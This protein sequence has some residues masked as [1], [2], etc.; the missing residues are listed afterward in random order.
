VTSAAVHYEASTICKM[1]IVWFNRGF[2]QATMLEIHDNKKLA[3]H[4]AA[5]RKK[6]RPA[7]P[8][9]SRNPVAGTDGRSFW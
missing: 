9:D 7:L 1:F 8:F 6:F 4:H 3:L 2:L 5:S